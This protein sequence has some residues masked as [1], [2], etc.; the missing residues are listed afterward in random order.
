MQRRRAALTLQFAQFV[1]N[2]D[3]QRRTELQRRQAAFHAAAAPLL[4]P[5][6]RR[7]EVRYREGR[8]VGYL[9]VPPTPPG[10]HSLSSFRD[11]NPPRSSS[12]PT[13]RSSF[14]AAWRPCQWMSRAG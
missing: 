6:A 13:N 7:V 8:V 4:D 11:W 9:R 12:A 5:P 14:V 1:L 10:R 3:R 2:E